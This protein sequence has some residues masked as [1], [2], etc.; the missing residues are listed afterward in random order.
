MNDQLLI[1]LVQDHPVLY[2]L[3]H[4]NYMDSSFKQEIWNVIGKAMKVDGTACKGRW[5]NIKD[6]YRKSLKRIS[7][8][9]GQNAKKIKLYKFSEELSFLQKYMC[10]RETKGKIVSQ[11][12]EE[13]NQDDV[14]QQHEDE[15]E[16]IADDEGEPTVLFA[17]LRKD[18]Q[19]QPSPSPKPTFEVPGKSSTGKSAKK[20]VAPQQT[21]SA[22]LLEYLISKQENQT[23]STSPHPVDAFLAGIAPTLKTLKPYYLNVAKSEIF[24]TVQKY[25]MQMLMNQHSFEGRTK[26]TAFGT[27][28]SNISRTHNS[29]I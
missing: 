18:L 25:E 27:S 10:E 22:K 8:K 6:N 23:A 12:D 15:E 29:N 1:E 20:E 26:P 14:A 21:P 19:T 24:A 13:N 3:S 16:H 7:T 28:A 11:Q 17:N 9:S 2:E 5:T 4:P